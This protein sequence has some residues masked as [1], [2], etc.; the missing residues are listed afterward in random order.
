[1]YDALG[2]VVETRRWKNVTLLLDDL[3]NGAVVVGKKVVTDKVVKNAWDGTGIAPGDFAWFSDGGVPNVESANCL[4]CS[5][6]EYD[7]AGRVWE[8]YSENED[9]DEICTQEILYDRAGR[10]A[11][12]ITLPDDSQNMAETLTGY[13][14]Q[15]QAWTQDARGNV[16]S[17]E[18]DALGRVVKTI[19]PATDYK[20]AGDENTIGSASGP[21][22][23]HVGYD[24][25]GRK[26]YETP[27]VRSSTYDGAD[28]YKIFTYDAAGR[29]AMVMLPE[30]PNPD[31]DDEP[32]PPIYRYIYDIY[33]NQVGILDPLGRVTRFTYFEAETKAAYFFSSSPALQNL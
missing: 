5:R 23:S 8:S 7:A 18:Y 16:T 25:F 27:P 31:N 26:L 11:K 10:Q 19:H 17:F 12:V 15:R 1:V 22:Y 3:Y 13:D 14:G 33:G 9:G 29:Q 20:V 2:R 6:T 24:G 32:E 28:K 21:V 4:S 30:V